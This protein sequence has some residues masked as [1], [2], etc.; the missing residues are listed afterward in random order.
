[1]INNNWHLTLS[2]V[3]YNHNVIWNYKL[4]AHVI[5][6]QITNYSKTNCNLIT[7]YNRNL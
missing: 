1:M 3:I 6:L 4:H 2:D 5:E 7:N